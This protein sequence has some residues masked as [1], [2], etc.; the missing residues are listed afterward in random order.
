MSAQFGCK[1]DVE[2]LE[3]S[4]A[5]GSQLQRDLHRHLYLRERSSLHHTGGR[6]GKVYDPQPELR[7]SRAKTLS[8]PSVREDAGV[9]HERAGSQPFS[10]RFRLACRV[11]A[12]AQFQHESA[13]SRGLR[14]NVGKPSVIGS[15]ILEQ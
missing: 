8:A 14:S 5:I 12:D 6:G 13:Q 2:E 10:I 11:Q 7:P 3:L 15:S 1:V 9:S 4:D